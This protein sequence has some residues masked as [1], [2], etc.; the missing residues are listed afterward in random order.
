MMAA[1]IHYRVPVIVH[2]RGEDL[3]GML[4]V[5]RRAGGMFWDGRLYVRP[6]LYM[7]MEQ[8]AT[9][10]NGGFFHLSDEAFLEQVRT[11]FGF[12]GGAYF[13]FVNDDFGPLSANIINFDNARRRVL[14]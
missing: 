9:P 12:K 13:D 1:F 3:S 8:P 14:H 2:H 7:T 5:A 10:K 4:T 6:T 11:V